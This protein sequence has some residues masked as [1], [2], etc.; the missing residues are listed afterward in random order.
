VD[1]LLIALVI[2]AFCVAVE[3]F[4][5]RYE[6]NRQ[7][8][9]EL[10]LKNEIADS[11]WRGSLIDEQR[12]QYAEGYSEDVAKARSQGWYRDTYAINIGTEAGPETMRAI[13]DGSITGANNRSHSVYPD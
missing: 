11:A 2:S 4:R 3:V 1:Y 6:K 5:R 7:A 10:A 12:E 8:S 13:R 9:A